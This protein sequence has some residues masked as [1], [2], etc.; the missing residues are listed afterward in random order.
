MREPGGRALFLGVAA[1]AFLLRLPFLGAGYGWDSDAWRVAAA[2]ASM[3]GS[4]QYAAPRLPGNPVH[5]VAAA[6]LWS[7][8]PAAQRPGVL[9]GASA[10]VSALGAGAFALAWRRRGLPDAALAGVAA[11]SVPA[12]FMASVSTLDYAWGFAFVAAALAAAT[13]GRTVLAAVFAALALGTRLSNAPAILAVALF[14]ADARRDR[15]GRARDIGVFLALAVGLGLLPYLP[16]WLERGADALRWYDH[17]YPPPVL[18]A[19]KLTVDLWGWIGTAALAA[20]ALA[21]AFR[22]TRGRSADARRTGILAAAGAALALA[23]FLRLPYKATYLVPAVPLLLLVPGAALGPRALRAVLVALVVSPWLLAVYAPGK[24]DDPG[25]SPLAVPVRV[26]GHGLVVDA[27]GTILLDHAR[28]EAGTAYV[29]RI[30]AAART[31]PPGSAL[32]VQDWLPALRLALDR[33]DGPLERDGV[34][35]TH[36][37]DAVALSRLRAEG[38]RLYYLPGV[39][40]ANVGKYGVDLVA[41]GARPLVP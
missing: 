26:A 9:N 23:A 36:L 12:V 2:A 14:L 18:V 37:L 4:G 3:A 29:A 7:L 32:V 38:R 30:A 10:L 16:L 39:E 35:Y 25:P 19:K 22:I 5:D 28:R 13:R 11:A 33:V 31:L 34:L 21:A 20:G 24:D 27:R 8:G 41:A 17:G 40:H 1:V 6:L 15:P